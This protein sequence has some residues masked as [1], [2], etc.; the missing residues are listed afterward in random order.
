MVFRYHRSEYRKLPVGQILFFT[1]AID[2]TTKV[3]DIV[4]IYDVHFSNKSLLSLEGAFNFNK[5]EVTNRR[6]SSAILPVPVLF[7]QAQIT[8]IEEGHPRQHHTLSGTY[9]RGPVDR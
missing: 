9:Y 6:S 8:L 7:D 4:A 5:T 1:N 3:F 2:T